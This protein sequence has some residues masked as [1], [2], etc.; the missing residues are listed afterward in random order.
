MIVSGLP[1]RLKTDFNGVAGAD[2][3]VVV[4]AP[5]PFH[6]VLAL[7]EVAEGDVE[8]VVIAGQPGTRLAEGL[9]QTVQKRRRFRRIGDP[10]LDFDRGFDVSGEFFQDHGFGA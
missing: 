2:R 7:A 8:V 1:R 6:E 4:A 9:L 3:G 10:L 5:L